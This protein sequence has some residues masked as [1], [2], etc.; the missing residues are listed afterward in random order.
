MKIKETDKK[1]FLFKFAVKTLGFGCAM[2][3]TKR[4]LDCYQGNCHILGGN[5]KYVISNV[6]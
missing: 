2:F 1:E 5:R 6:L 3:T 4:N